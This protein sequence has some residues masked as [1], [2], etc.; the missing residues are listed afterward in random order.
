[1]G[2]W[3]VILGVPIAATLQMIVTDILEVHDKKVAI[4]AN[5]TAGADND[6]ETGANKE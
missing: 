3:G 1:M 6:T 5:E 2:F 4:E